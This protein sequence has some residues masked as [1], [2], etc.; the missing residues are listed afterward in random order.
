MLQ[1]ASEPLVVVLR[2]RLTRLES[3]HKEDVSTA[4]TPPPIA[5]TESVLVTS[6]RMR[7]AVRKFELTAWAHNRDGA[8]VRVGR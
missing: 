1:A 8:V 6:G 7:P 4:A 2:T 3:M 5:T